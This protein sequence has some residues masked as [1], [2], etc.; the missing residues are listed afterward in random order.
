MAKK[1]TPEEIAEYQRNWHRAHPKKDRILAVPKRNTGICIRPKCRNPR[2]ANR[3]YCP[4]C[5]SR[6]SSSVADG[7]EF[8]A[9]YDD[10]EEE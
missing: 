4:L 5:L 1:K 9:T 3:Y 6:L 2:G 7:F 8:C 10:E